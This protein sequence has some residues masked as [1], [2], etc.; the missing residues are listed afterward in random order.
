MLNGSMKITQP[1]SHADHLLRQTRVDQLQLSQMADLK[2]NMLLTMASVVMT[3]TVP[4]AMEPKLRLP[5][6]ILI[7]FCLATIMLATY[8]AMPK[9]HLWRRSPDRRNLDSP[10]FNLLFFGDFTILRYEDFRTTMEQ[11]LNNPSLA[12][13]AQVR[14]IYN[15]GRFLK[16]KKFRYVQLGYMSFLSGLL[17]SGLLLLVS[18]GIV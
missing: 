9:F 10:D 6:L 12:Y 16:T 1:G 13:E 8:A 15:A 18:S 14:E 17:T 11:V 2:A 4:H 7:A 5:A 3:L